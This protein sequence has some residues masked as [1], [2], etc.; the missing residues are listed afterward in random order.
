[1]MMRRGSHHQSRPSCSS[2]CCVWS[3]ALRWIYLSENQ[4]KGGNCRARPGGTGRRLSGAGATVSACS[5]NRDAA[6]GSSEIPG[7]RKDVV[8]PEPTRDLCWFGPRTGGWLGLRLL[9]SLRLDGI[10][11]SRGPNGGFSG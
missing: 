11:S 6:L 5:P 7:L 9:D 8:Q 4:T 3:F 10:C 1:D 2:R